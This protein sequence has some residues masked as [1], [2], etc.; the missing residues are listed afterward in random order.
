M[1]Y[2]QRKDYDGNLETVDE[3]ESRKEAVNILKEYRI[4]DTSAFYYISQK[5][6]RD[7]Q[8]SYKEKS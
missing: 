5:P 1:R 4:Y 3:F 8:E 2:I 6:C 7:W